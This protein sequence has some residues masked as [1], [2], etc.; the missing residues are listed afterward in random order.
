[1]ADLPNLYHPG[2]MPDLNPRTER[3]VMDLFDRVNY[4]T[5]TMGD[6]QGTLKTISNSDSTKGIPGLITIPGILG[7][8]FIRV[9]ENG[10]V[11]KY[12]SPITTKGIFRMLFVDPTDHGN[13]GVVATTLISINIPAGTLKL[14]GDFLEYVAEFVLANNG[15]S[16]TIN[17]SFGG[18]S[19]NTNPWTNTVGNVQM[20]LIGRIYRTSPTTCR[21]YQA[22]SLPFLAQTTDFTQFSDITVASMDST[23]LVF[24]VA[25]Q[26][27]ASN[28]IV[29]KVSHMMVVQQ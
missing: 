23:G 25:A 2:T 21:S 16:K 3:I 27:G 11:I 19:L 7:D 24:T 1:M 4:L 29:H 20:V 26:A 18:A 9:D 10:A 14:T 5:T 17:Y 13:S 8:G 28:D 15:N 22:A 6:V 12:A